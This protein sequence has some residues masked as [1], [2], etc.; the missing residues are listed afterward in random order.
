[1]YVTPQ[2]VRIK[3]ISKQWK[4][5]KSENRFCV[6]THIQTVR[7]LKNK[8][9]KYKVSTIEKLEIRKLENYESFFYKNQISDAIYFLFSVKFFPTLKLDQIWSC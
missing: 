8:R 9:S 4:T 1:M 2:R 5:A 3:N 6:H 7:D